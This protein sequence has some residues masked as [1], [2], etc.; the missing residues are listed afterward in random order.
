M[1][2][3]PPLGSG[4]IMIWRVD[5]ARYAR[6]WKRGTGAK[7]FGGR[8]NSIGRAVVYASLDPATAILEVAVHRGFRLMDTVPH[9]LTCA[10]IVNP[11]GAH[12]VSPE[13]VPDPRWLAPRPPADTAPQAFGD[14][15]LTRFPLV[16]LPSIVSRRSWNAV[17]RVKQTVMLTDVR[18]EPLIIDPRL[19]SEPDAR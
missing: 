13:D 5:A 10:T 6:S 12:V 17:L 15:L 2:L 14:D 8:W 19:H 9:V 11:T 1:S 3:P 18:Q 7:I 4:A 16:I